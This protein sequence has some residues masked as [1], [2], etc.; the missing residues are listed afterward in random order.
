MSIRFARWLFLVAG[1][2]GVLLV[3]PNYFLETWAGEF[4]PPSI[5]HPELF[6]GFVGVVLAWQL[7]YLLI[8]SDPVRYRPPMLLG[9][10]G[11]ASFA[12]ALLLLF[13]KGRVSPHWLGFVAFDG[14]L[15]ILFVVAYLRVPAP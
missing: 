11:K 7:M 4:D 13:A 3:A 9:A 8:A 2:L 6:Y 10:F 12:V 1:V 5:N 14:T 15:S